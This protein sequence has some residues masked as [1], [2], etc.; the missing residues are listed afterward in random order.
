MRS[1]AIKQGLERAPHRAFLHAAGVTR[2]GLDRPFI[3]IADASTD[4]V[5][6]HVH[7]GVLCRAVERGI[8]SAGGQAFRFGVPAVCDG[9]LMGHRGMHYSLPLREIIADAVESV[10]TAHALDGLVLLTNCDKITPGMLMALARLDIPGIVVTGGPMLGGHREGKRTLCASGLFEAIGLRQAGR[11]SDEDLK[12]QELNACPTPGACQGMYTA[13]TM[14]CV[15]EALGLTLPF[16]ATAPAVSA[17]RA[18]IA[19]ES[20][21]RVV[22]LVR[23]GLTA[24]RFL[25]EA[26]FRNA[27]RASMAL[28]GSTNVALH[29]PA[30]AREAGVPVGLDLFDAISRATPTLCDLAPGGPDF[31]E[32]LHHAGGL[33]GVLRHLGDRIEEAPTVAGPGIRA[34]AD[35]AR[36]LSAG[37]IRPA[38]HPVLPDGGI[39][40]LRGSLAPGGAVVKQ[41]AVAPEARRLRGPARVFDAEEAAVEAIL[42]GRVRPGTVV[43][44]RHEGPRGGPGMREML[45][46]TSV[47][48]GLGLGA[49]VG[50][51]TDGRFSGGTRG[52]CVGHVSPEAPAGGPIGLVREDDL[53]EIDSPGRRLDLHVDPA[54]LARR[55]A[56]YKPIEPKIQ[57]G[58]LA[59]YARLVGSAAEGAVLE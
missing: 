38:T 7:L 29:V 56:A 11:I 57:T 9:M 46:P 12:E 37:I 20:G 32:D 58:W 22:A 5:P 13:N 21:E 15:A 43:V 54:E 52:P 35:A 51:V 40:V 42:A 8:H 27:V 41:S 44:I 39:A 3:G 34:V 17:E 48:V 19:F 16:G 33:P 10:A 45:V 49:S 24:R 26:A 55:R 25:T 30:I 14:A 28:G 53:I 2:S 36:V 50:L 6:G 1:D 31:V 18:R 4:L 59:R 23:D 47:L